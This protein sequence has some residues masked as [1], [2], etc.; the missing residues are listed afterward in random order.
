[1]LT[2]NQAAVGQE[3]AICH[4]DKVHSLLLLSTWDRTSSYPHLQWQFEMRKELLRRNELELCMDLSNLYLF[5]PAFVNNNPALLIERKWQILSTLIP[6]RVRTLIGHYDADLA[7]DTTDRLTQVT[8]PTLI[9][10]GITSAI[11]V[12]SVA[13]YLIRKKWLNLKREK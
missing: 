11:G 9:I 5:S 3:L 1:M 10:V 7:H 4:P 6:E 8:A 13:I 2:F 12:G